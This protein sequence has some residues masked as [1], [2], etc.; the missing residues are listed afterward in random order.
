LV[1]L[2]DGFI[3]RKMVAKYL[4]LPKY[5]ISVLS[6]NNFTNKIIDGLHITNEKL[7]DDGLASVNLSMIYIPI[8]I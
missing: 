4:F 3:D 1:I 5:S 6:V 7:I 2:T 8:K